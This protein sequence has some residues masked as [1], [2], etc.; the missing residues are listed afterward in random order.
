MMSWAASVEVKRM[1]ATGNSPWWTTYIGKSV[2]V[3]VCCLQS[4]KQKVDVG[5]PSWIAHANG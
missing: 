5:P 4:L 2:C 3:S 1:K